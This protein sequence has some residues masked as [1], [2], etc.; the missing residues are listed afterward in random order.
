MSYATCAEVRAN[1]SAYGRLDLEVE[2]YPNYANTTS[3]CAPSAC[4]LFHLH[5]RENCRMGAVLYLSQFG[6]FDPQVWCTGPA[7]LWVPLT[8]RSLCALQ[9]AV[10]AVARYG[11]RGGGVEAP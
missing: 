8:A 11:P 2:M 3:M 6:V 10:D 7:P 5:D 1:T 9:A 4:F